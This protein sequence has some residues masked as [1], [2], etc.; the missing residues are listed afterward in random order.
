MHIAEGPPGAFTQIDGR[1][2]LYFAGTGYLGLQGHPEVI[3]AACEAA[4]AYGIGSANSRTAFGTTQPVLDVER[5]AAAMFG[6]EAAFYFASG[7]MGNNVLV[8]M[9]NGDARL[10]LVDECSHYSLFE[11]AR[12]TGGSTIVFHHRDTNDLR[13]KL[14]KH[15]RPG[16]FP[17]VLSDGVFA[18]TGRIAP[19]DQYCDALREY[20]G[21][22]LCLDDAHALAVLGENGRGTYEHL[23]LGLADRGQ[24][25]EVNE[26][27]SAVSSQRSENRNSQFPNQ[28]IP[29]IAA[30]GPHPNPL[31]K[32][33][34]TDGSGQRAAVSSQRSETT[35]QNASPSAIHY[36]LSTASSS[37]ALLLSGTLSKAVGGFGGI[38]PGSREFIEQIK[39]RSP[40]FGGA[41]APPAPIA[42][43]TAKAL[44]IIMADPGLRERLRSNVRKLKD[45]LR[46]LGFDVDDSPVPIVSL[47]VGTSEN[48]QRIQRELMERGIAVAYMASYAGLGPEGALRLA[49]FATHTEEMIERLMD[50]LRRFV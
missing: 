44:E 8:Q 23:G 16:Q 12:L 48:M 47:T 32:G 40:Y 7:W 26:E 15:L 3:R 29:G 13:E 22:V 19:A 20:P 50:G 4:Q 33:E 41:S 42:A 46:R 36:P 35:N 21:A 24:G 34:G 28:Q 18:A 10:V 11:A 27:R 1:Q 5:A 39:S 14:K 25:A 2:Y 45:G 49:V 38:I 31:P 17:L 6:M 37:P 30:N 43:A 9:L